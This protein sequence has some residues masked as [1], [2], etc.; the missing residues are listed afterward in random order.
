MPFL[1]RLGYYLFGLS[2]GLVFLAFFLKKKTDETGTY[3]CYLPNCRVLKELRSK[4]LSMD[5]PD[6]STSEHTLDSTKIGEFLTNGK[7]NFKTS[8][9]KAVPCGLYVINS[10]ENVVPA[11]ITVENCR[12]SVKVIAY[13]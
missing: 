12:D 6:A 9:T 8:D 2:I 4:P 1:K 11:Q 13:Q 3:F 10:R 7:V 5:F